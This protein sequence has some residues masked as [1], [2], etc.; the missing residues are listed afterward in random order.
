M[1][2]KILSLL[3]VCSTVYAQEDTTASDDFDF[4]DFELAAPA[5]KAFC[6]NKVLGQ[7]PTSLIGA[8]YNFQGPHDFTAGNLID[9]EFTEDISE[10]N[11]I[12]ATHGFSLVGNFPLISRNNILVNLNVIYNEQ[13]YQF[14]NSAK[15][16][17]TQSLQNSPLR[18][19]NTVLTVFK[20][21][22]DTRFILGQVGFGLNGDYSF[23]DFQ[24]L[25]TTRISAALLYGFKPSDRLMYA[26]GLSRTYLAG[27]LNYVPIIYYFHTFKNESWG[28]EALLPARAFLRYRFNSTSLM[29]IGYN[30]VGNTYRLNEFNNNRQNLIDQNPAFDQPALANADDF[31]LRRSEIRAGL[32]YSQAI[33]GFFWLTAEAGYRINY[34]YELDEGGDF[35]RFFGNDTDYF[36]ENTLG[37]PLY[38]QIGISYVSP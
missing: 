38:F 28:V 4:S 18:S 34:S 15:Y 35:L 20:P 36:I 7:S 37:N 33:S 6:N 11:N 29:G 14:A 31:E 17:L 32:R 3:L 13:H 26:F 8:Y 10:E 9:P 19:A 24:S 22:N 27:A 2:K 25:S 5:S 16:P 21:L 12:E 23:N 30:V 1:L